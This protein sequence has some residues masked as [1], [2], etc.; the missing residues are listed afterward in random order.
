MKPSERRALREQKQ[1]E[2]QNPTG[3]VTEQTE[4]TVQTGEMHKDDCSSRK[5]GLWQ[6]HPKLI[7]FISCLLV[8]FIFFGPYNVWDVIEQIEQK[9][10]MKNI[11][12]TYIPMNTVYHLSEM[13][14]GIDWI[15]FE[16]YYYTDMSYEING[17]EHVKREYYVGDNDK[18][19]GYI[20][21]VGGTTLDES[22]EYVYL[23]DYEGTGDV[24][25]IRREN[26]AKFVEQTIV[27]REDD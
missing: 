26:A 14:A 8:F 21:W 13:G 9:R 2:L 12:D 10:Q 5:Q 11:T 17:E 6:T 18:S 7:T 23:I 27:Q 19:S 4:Q 25:D 3:V 22:P 20:I 15:H 16:K 24:I 1:Q